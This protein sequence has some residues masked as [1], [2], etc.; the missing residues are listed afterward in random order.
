MSAGKLENTE[1]QQDVLVAPPN[2][3]D[4]AQ[5]TALRATTNSQTSST[6]ANIGAN[7]LDGSYVQPQ[8]LRAASSF[9]SVQPIYRESYNAV[10]LSG[11][12]QQTQMPNTPSNYF[13]VQNNPDTAGTFSSYAPLGRYPPS[14]HNSA[15][16]QTSL[17]GWTAE[18]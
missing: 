10:P 9:S 15:W 7:S 18:G 5:E 17:G 4:M 6:N 16:S 2:P 12:Y 1:D 13:D 3:L 11:D 14:H 8:P